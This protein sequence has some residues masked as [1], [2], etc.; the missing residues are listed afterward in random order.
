[1]NVEGLVGKIDRQLFYIVLEIYFLFVIL[2]GRY[3]SK[4]KIISYVSNE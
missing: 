1:M 2:C 4:F 3:L